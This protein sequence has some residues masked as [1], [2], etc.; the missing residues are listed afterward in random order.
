MKRFF[1]SLLLIVMLALGSISS[2]YAQCA[3]CKAVAK[4]NIDS[5]SNAV[6]K[7][8]NRGVLYLLAIPYVLAGVGGVIWYRNRNKPVGLE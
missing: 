7:G 4:S 3:M 2:S 5:H 6:G 8:I 1:A